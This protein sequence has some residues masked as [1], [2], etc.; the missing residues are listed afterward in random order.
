MYGLKHVAAGL[1]ALA[2]LSATPRQA[3]AAP[4]ASS[5]ADASGAL[6]NVKAY[7]AKGD[8]RLIRNDGTLAAGSSRLRAP[9]AHFGPQDIGKSIIIYYAGK[10]GAGWAGKAGDLVTTIQQVL[11]PATVVLGTP[12][13]SAVSNACGAFGSDDSKAFAAAFAGA[14]SSGESLLSFGAL[15]RA[16][17][18]EILIPAATGYMITRPLRLAASN[19]TVSA[20]GSIIYYAGQGTFLE[21]GSRDADF[22]QIQIRGLSVWGTYESAV[23]ISMTRFKRAHLQDCFV[24]MIPVGIMVK[25]RS[26]CEIYVTNC[27]V[28]RCTTGVIL[29]PPSNGSQ[30]NGVTIDDYTRVGV[31]V[32]DASA[33]AATAISLINVTADGAPR[34]A[35]AAI[36]VGC[37]HGLSIIG[38]Y[39]END[40]DTGAG[41]A[42]RL[43]ALSP[44]GCNTQGVVIEGGLYNGHSHD[45]PAILLAGQSNPPY[46][47]AVT[48]MSNYFQNWSN[49]V[50]IERSG[51]AAR[52]WLI[53]PNAFVEVGEKYFDRNPGHGIFIDGA[54]HR[55]DEQRE[56]R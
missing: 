24:T 50:R 10:P 43:G 49:G 1:A 30:L 6:F 55:G 4:Y 36:D 31:Q 14:L 12:A 5:P 38:Q 13:G 8:V 45:N 19:V 52:D 23:G 46:V 35:V 3:A 16:G 40:T 44:S 20:Y 27:R 56:P 21:L 34:T 33:S 7:G 22:S 41:V 25:G 18:A 11:G 17:N 26:T 2:L 29:G 54:F 28:D 53:G 9:S 39:A 42:V 47:D 37:V 32:G 51:T 15:P 48:I